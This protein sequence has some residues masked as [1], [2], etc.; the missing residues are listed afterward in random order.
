MNLKTKIPLH[1]IGWLTFVV[2]TEWN[3]YVYEDFEN[4]RFIIDVTY[5]VALIL[6]FYFFYLLVWPLVLKKR[7]WKFVSFLLLGILL[8][9]GSRY[10]LQEVFNWHVFG[11]T[12][13]NPN[14]VTLL[15][16][17]R[18]NWF[19]P[20]PVI[21][22]SAFVFLFEV[23]QENQKQQLILQQEKTA[24][25]LAFL[26]GQINPH[27]LFNTLNLIHT[28]AFSKDPELAE[29]IQKISGILRYAVD[30]SASGK[31]TIIEEINLLKDYIA[32][33]KKRFENNCFVNFEI[34][35]SGTEQQIE[36]L[37]LI[38]FV[39]NAFKHGQFSDPNNSI[40]FVLETKTGYLTFESSNK[41]K[42]Q[43]KDLTSGV[44]I[45][46]VRKRLNVLYPDKH[47][48]VIENNPTNYKVSLALE[49]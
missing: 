46:N 10:F 8:F 47:T 7:W 5:I 49:L 14:R 34:K 32:I 17:L 22:G 28:E 1:I 27:F 42:R 38:P 12:N 11:F 37:L 21:L 25:E 4:Y 2:Y 39:E 9:I 29:T 44:G 35:G 16:Y 24:A 41:V 18:D 26:R 20:I 6:T 13:Y 33:F 19:R 43:V 31:R 40:N 45:E 30:S 3:D 48:F 23:N 15:Y 36:P